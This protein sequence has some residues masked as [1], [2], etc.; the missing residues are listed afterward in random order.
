MNLVEL[1][2]LNF[3]FLALILWEVLKVFNLLRVNEV[4]AVVETRIF[5]G[6]PFLTL[7]V[8]GIYTLQVFL[9]QT[10]HLDDLCLPL[11]C[12]IIAVSTEQWTSRSEQEMGPDI[13]RPLSYFLSNRW[14]IFGLSSCGDRYL[15]SCLQTLSGSS[16]TPTKLLDLRSLLAADFGFLGREN[17]LGLFTRVRLLSN[18]NL[19][20]LLTE[21]WFIL[22]HRVLP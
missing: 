17:L 11:C 18:F 13:W 9:E 19:A 16:L 22:L 8:E 3:G 5:F 20:R 21:G 14:L 2:E 7:D 6:L 10:H 1:F 15:F 4:V 12:V